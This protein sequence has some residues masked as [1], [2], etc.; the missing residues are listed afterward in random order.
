[1]HLHSLPPYW[2]D[3]NNVE[4]AWR[5]LHAKVTRN[6]HCDTIDELMAEADKYLTDQNQKKH[7]LVLLAA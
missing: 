1:L 7:A 4:R 5:E 3:H 2:P 6:H